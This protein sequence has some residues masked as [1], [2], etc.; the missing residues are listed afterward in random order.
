MVTDLDLAGAGQVTVPA[1]QDD[2][3]G[4][5]S[6][7]LPVVAPLTGE[8]RPS[9]ENRGSV[10]HSGDRFACARPAGEPRTACPERSSA[11]DGIQAQ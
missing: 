8:R 10:E 4:F 6:R 7:G 5:A 3:G 2:T 1:D 9:G 11:L